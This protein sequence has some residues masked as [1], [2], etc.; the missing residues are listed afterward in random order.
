[1][2]LDDLA[3]SEFNGGIR[4]IRAIEPTGPIERAMVWLLLQAYRRRLRATVAA[5]PEWVG[6]EI[7][8]ASEGVGD[9]RAAVC[10]SENWRI[11]PLSRMGLRK[12]VYMQGLDR[13]LRGAEFW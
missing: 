12:E 6:E 13:H 3:T 10:L 2:A 9:D 4:L 11:C 7:L 5:A 8:G 1:M